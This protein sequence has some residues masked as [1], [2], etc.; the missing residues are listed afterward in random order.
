MQYEL[1]VML[2]PLLPDDVR[3]ELHKEI[4]DVT[5]EFG[6]EVEDTDVWGKR[7]LSYNI[8]THSEGY[9][10]L[11]LMEIDPSHIKEFTRK[12]NLRPEV[13]RFMFV[14]IE[15]DS[16]LKQTVKKKQMEEA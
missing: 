13:L 11:Y 3:K 14:K 10:I 2:K 5:K 8:G 16:Q 6:G 1:M 4:L 12:L 9:Y 7:Y 15:D